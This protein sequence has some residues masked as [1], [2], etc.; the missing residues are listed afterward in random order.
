MLVTHDSVEASTC[1]V[2]HTISELRHSDGEISVAF[3]TLVEDLYV[4]RTVHRFGGGKT[5]VGFGD[6][7][8]VGSKLV[9]VTGFLV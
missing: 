1:F 5:S 2:S 6:E 3:D 8:V 4:T 9:P 7:H